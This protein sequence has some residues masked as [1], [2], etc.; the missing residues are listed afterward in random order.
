MEL[1]DPKLFSLRVRKGVE[2]R[3]CGPQTSL[4][5]AVVESKVQSLRPIKGNSQ[6]EEAEENME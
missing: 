4:K 5:T 1:V 3:H 6:G 2:D